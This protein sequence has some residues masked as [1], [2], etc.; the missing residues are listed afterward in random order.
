[1]RLTN[2]EMAANADDEDSKDKPNLKDH[3]VICQLAIKELG[4]YYFPMDHTWRRQRN[5]MCYHLFMVEGTL[6][7]FK[8]HVLELK[9]PRPIKRSTNFFFATD[10]LRLA[11]MMVSTSSMVILTMLFAILST[12]ALSLSANLLWDFFLSVFEI[13]RRR[14][15]GRG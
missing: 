6:M 1:M 9:T 11:P 13:A 3:N 4:R 14:T 2:L 7:D 10:H 8:S 5:Y 15:F 12:L